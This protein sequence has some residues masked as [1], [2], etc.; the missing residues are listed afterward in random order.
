MFLW[1]Q[2]LFLL[3]KWLEVELPYYREH[4]FKFRTEYLTDFQSDRAILHTHQECMRALI[5]QRLFSIQYCPWQV[6]LGFSHYSGRVSVSHCGF[7]LHLLHDLIILSTFYI[8]YQ[9]FICVFF[10]WSA[11][12]LLSHASFTFFF[13]LNNWVILLR[14]FHN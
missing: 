12:S 2:V 10:V 4:T 9:P 3:D 1:T 13:F 11:S 6:R 8:T 5:A 7:N 14:L